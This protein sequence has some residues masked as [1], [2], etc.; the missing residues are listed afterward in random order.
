MYRRG[1]RAE[2]LVRDALAARG[3]L[4]LRSYA[5]RGPFD[6]LAVTRGRPPLLVEV[7]GYGAVMGPVA[8]ARLV[9]EAARVG[10]VPVLA[11]YAAGTITYQRL[12]ASGFGPAARDVDE[13]ADWPT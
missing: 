6:L 10:A 13:L 5:S 12:D 3:Y 1:A 8:R 11:H 7:K 2:Y 9:S 4:V